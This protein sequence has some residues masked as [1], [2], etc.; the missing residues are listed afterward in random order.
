M[1][2]ETA[3]HTH[4][5]THVDTQSSPL[6]AEKRSAAGMSMLAACVM[7]ALKLLAGL[8]TG[9]L[10]LLSDAAHSGLDLLGAALTFFSVRISDKPA[11]EDHPY[12]HGKIE[13][14]SAFTETFL[15]AVSCI[16]IVTEAVMRIFIHPVALSF[17]VWPFAVLGLSI[18]VDYTR[19]R[20]LGRVAQRSG[21]QALEAVALHFSSDIWSSLA[22]A[23]GLLAS[24]LGVVFHQ[25]WLRFADP[26]AALLVSAVILRFSWRLAHRTIAVLLDAAPAGSRR[27]IVDAIS[28]LTGVLGV[29]RV[30]VRRSGNGYFA[31]LSVAVPRLD[32]FQHTE[33]LVER[34]TDTVER[35]L[36]QT[37]V[38]VHTVPREGSSE[39]IFDKIRGVASRNNVGLHDVSVHSTPGGFHVEQ[40]LELPETMPLRDAHKFVCDIESQMRRELPEIRSVLTHIESEPDTIERPARLDKERS[41]EEALRRTVAELGDAVLDV[42]DIVV[43]HVGD[44]VYLSCHCTLPDDLPM[45]KVHD[46]IT[47]LENRFKLA[48]PQVSRVLIHPEPLADNKHE[49]Q[50]KESL[51]QN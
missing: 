9:S 24:D 7:T 49:R 51:V 32:T 45:H 35:I 11:D 4:A 16:W 39:S 3:A 19:A 31:D 33:A 41:L 18:A 13:T 40:H 29:E 46:V 47:E 6:S 5:H 2:P 48:Y 28:N 15:M 14:L 44:R 50:S 43:R 21:S 25:P 12:G 10:G 23:L 26:V 42:H 37:D 17:T 34:I 20:T 38:V 1:G 30:R 27:R 8:L 36:P 22:V